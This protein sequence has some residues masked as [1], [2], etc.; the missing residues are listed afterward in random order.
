MACVFEI[1]ASGSDEQFVEDVITAALDEVG[2][3]DQ[4]LSAY[5][6]TSELSFVNAEA[7]SRPII[8]DP[9]FFRLL[10]TAKQL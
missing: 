5:L 8:V 2:R 7:A 4:M 9:D 3:L 10:G 6:P 1:T